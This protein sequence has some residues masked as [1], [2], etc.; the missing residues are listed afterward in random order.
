MSQ[1]N[2][3]NHDMPAVCDALA[4]LRDVLPKDGPVREDF[5]LVQSFI[6]RAR[7]QIESAGQRTTTIPAE[8]Q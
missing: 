4:R 8:K 2:F 1:A 3:T 5:L 7:A 6:T